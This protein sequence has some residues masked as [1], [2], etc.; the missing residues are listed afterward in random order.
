MSHDL[1]NAIRHANCSR[2]NVEL[3]SSIVM[4]YAKMSDWMVSMPPS[5]QSSG[6]SHLWE[7]ETLKQIE[8]VLGK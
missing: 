6:A 1:K 2:L 8:S 5:L 4:P 7:F 3:T